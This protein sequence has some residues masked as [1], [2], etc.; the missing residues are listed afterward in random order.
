MV[1]SREV[2]VNK[3]YA[4]CIG[5][6]YPGTNVELAGCVNDARD[7]QELLANAGYQVS[8]LVEADKATALDALDATIAKAGWGDRVVFTFSGHGTWVP[9]RS[10]DEADRRDEAM[11]MTDYMQGGLLLDDEIQRS[12]SVLKPGA[13]GLILGDEC[14]SGTVSRFVNLGLKPR[15]VSPHTFI[16]DLTLE[17]ARG[18]EVRAAA[19]VPHYSS[20]ISGCEDQQYSYDAW[21]GPPGHERP[22][23]AFT[24][25][26]IDTYWPGQSL[27]TWYKRIR[28]RLPDDNYPQSPVLTAASLYRKYARAI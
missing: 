12:F 28:E 25:A 7:W 19:P 4:L 17:Q 27:N 16:E 18:M 5:N 14:H 26:A 8:V 9:D 2:S 20:L 15:F 23:G 24:R 3:K 1:Q 13:G 10:G 21:F 6:N 11:C 22:N